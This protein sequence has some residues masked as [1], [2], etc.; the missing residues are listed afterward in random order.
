MPELLNKAGP[1]PDPFLWGTTSVVG[2]FIW[3]VAVINGIASAL[4]IGIANERVYVQRNFISHGACPEQVR[5][6]S[7]KQF[8][9]QDFQHHSRRLRHDAMSMADPLFSRGTCT[10]YYKAGPAFH[11]PDSIRLSPAIARSCMPRLVPRHCSARAPRDIS[12][13]QRI[14]RRFKELDAL[15]KLDQLS[16]ALGHPEESGVIGNA[17]GLRQV[18]GDDDHRQA[19]A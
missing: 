10:F 7:L 15:A 12:L 4:Y 1:K 17:A 6:A 16:D 13:G 14:L 2:I 19:A 3:L 5:P 11:L 9:D 8:V 18:V